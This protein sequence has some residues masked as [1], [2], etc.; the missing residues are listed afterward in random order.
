MVVAEHE[1]VGGDVNALR[2]LATL[3]RNGIGTEEPGVFNDFESRDPLKYRIH[4]A[5]KE[6]SAERPPR[7]V[8]PTFQGAEISV[9]RR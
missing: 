5:Q 4:L 1:R 6:R 3:A 7:A 2:R 9:Q 8:R